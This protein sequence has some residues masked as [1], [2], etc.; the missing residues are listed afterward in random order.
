MQ[1]SGEQ[2]QIIIGQEVGD[3]YKLIC[4]KSGLEARAAINENLDK[5]PGV[6]K[7]TLS[8]PPTMATTF[9]ANS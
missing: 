8:F 6:K 3:A 2:L 9:S 5:E 7:E 4:E 1:Q